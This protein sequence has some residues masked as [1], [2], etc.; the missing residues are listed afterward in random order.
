GIDISSLGSGG[1]N[2]VQGNFIGTDVT[3]TIALG[4]KG[5][6][7]STQGENILV[8][9][10][11][12]GAGNVVS[13]TTGSAPFFV[14]AGINPTGGIGVLVQG[15]LIGTNASGTA[16]LP[17]TRNGIYLTTNGTFDTI[18]GIVPTARNLISGNG[19][20]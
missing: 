8:G 14:G 6:G 4:N 2:R 17:N 12:A 15:N 13:G 9:G 20:D 19:A 7:V 5:F 10:T 18:G 11:T 16:A 1:T 3:G